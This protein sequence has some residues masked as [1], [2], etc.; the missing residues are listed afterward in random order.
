[1][2]ILFLV[3]ISFF[4]IA[5]TS[6]ENSKHE[7]GANLRNDSIKYAVSYKDQLKVVVD[8]LYWYRDY[9]SNSHKINMVNN[10]TNKF[11]STKFY[12]VNF[13]GTEQYLSDMKKSGFL[14]EKYIEQWRTY[15]KQCDL[16]FKKNPQND[17]PPEGFEYDF[18]M[19]S[20][21]YEDDLAK[22]NKINIGKYKGDSNKFYLTIIFPST[23]SLEFFLS[24]NDGKWLI[25]DIN[26]PL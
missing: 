16:S 3:I 13:K 8:F 26:N 25:D 24:I 1:M 4:L 19:F 23:Q 2:K 10:C 14:S 17:G 12:S 20:Q 7:N 6:K 21:D 22:L 15:F 18:V 11:D 5:C 9:E